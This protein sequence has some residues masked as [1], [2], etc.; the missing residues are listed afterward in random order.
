MS[1]SARSHATSRTRATDYPDWEPRDQVSARFTK[2]VEFWITRADGRPLV[3]ASHGMAMTL[4]LASTIGLADPGA[5]WAGLRL[6]DLL[7]VDLTGRQVNP[8]QVR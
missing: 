3:I 4:W 8:V 2:G 7:A 6:P 5:F 1:D